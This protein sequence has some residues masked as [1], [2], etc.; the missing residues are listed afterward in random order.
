MVSMSVFQ[1]PPKLLLRVQRWA[2]WL[3]PFWNCTTLALRYTHQC[4]KAYRDPIL[5]LRTLI[6]PLRH[7]LASLWTNDIIQPVICITNKAC[8]F[9]YIYHTWKHIIYFPATKG[10]VKTLRIMAKKMRLLVSFLSPITIEAFF[11]PGSSSFGSTAYL[12]VCLSQY[13]P[14]ETWI[15]ITLTVE[16]SRN[17]SL[18]L[19]SLTVFLCNYFTITVYKP[20]ILT[21]YTSAI[22]SRV[23]T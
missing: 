14:N 13:L 17:C 8:I 15:E 22:F 6:R 9:N 5:F 18:Y 4:S 20:Y 16:N 1:N 21:L 11:S 10:L 19:S 3:F 7:E 12:I 2:P 23:W